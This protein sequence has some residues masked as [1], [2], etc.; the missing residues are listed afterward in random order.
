[1]VERARRV[2]GGKSEGSAGSSLP[3]FDRGDQAP[4]REHDEVVELFIIARAGGDAQPEDEGV[5]VLAIAGDLAPVSARHHILL[6]REEGDEFDPSAKKGKERA[7]FFERGDLVLLG[8]EDEPLVADEGAA[9]TLL[10]CGGDG[11][12]FG[13]LMS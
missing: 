7:L 11:V 9:E 5:E 3:P 8:V 10:P 13:G 1:M 2:V 6:W 12:P 4:D